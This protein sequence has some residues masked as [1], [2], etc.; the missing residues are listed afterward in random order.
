MRKVSIALCLTAAIALSVAGCRSKVIDKEQFHSALNSYYANQQSCL[1]SSPVKFPVQADTDDDAK[2]QHYDAL[3]D[4]GLLTRIPAE[5]KR[6]LIGSKNVNNYDLSDQGRSNW[7]ADPSA[8]G[9]G[10]FCFG[11]PK[12]T[13]IDS[14]TPDTGGATQ[15]SVNYH[16]GV[17]LPGWANNAEIQ[18]AFPS[19]SAIGNGQPGTA[20]L[21][22]ANNGWQVQNVSPASAA[23]QQ[24]Q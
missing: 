9:Y 23:P 22:Q 10:N 11:H 15:Y 3:T 13:S 21:I 14:F 24:A 12:V 17:T 20:T 1:W 7:T 5:K 18:T 16:Y 19:V 6:F 4:A 8:P 2:R